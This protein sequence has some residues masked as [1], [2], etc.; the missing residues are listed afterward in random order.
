MAG[1][2]I[3]KPGPNEH[4]PYFST[5]I[6]RVQ[7]GD[8]LVDLERQA[9]EIA[10]LCGGLSEAQGEYR[11]AP[12]K[13]SIK[14]LLGHLID[15]ERVFGFRALWFA[16]GAATELPGFEQDDFVRGADFDG[17][18]VERLISEFVHLR[19]STVDLLSSF[20]E[21]DW[22]QSGISSGVSLSVRAIGYILVGHVIHHQGIL[23]ER[24]LR[25]FTQ[26]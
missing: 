4:D 6:D 7:E 16:R 25:R 19:R 17:R 12:D 11:Y 8:L 2:R 21:A 24:Y 22:A 13:W 14:E 26:Q 18:S 1:S 10:E 23:E 5:Y 9:S 20:R 15:T 3:P